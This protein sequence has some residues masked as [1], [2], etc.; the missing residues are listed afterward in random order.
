MLVKKKFASCPPNGL[1]LGFSGLVN[2]FASAQKVHVKLKTLENE[3]II[4]W[5]T[6]VK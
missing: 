1:F 6:N 2:S 5:N 3:K 4:K